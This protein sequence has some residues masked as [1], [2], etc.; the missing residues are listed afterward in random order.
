MIVRIIKDEIDIIK[1]TERNVNA[2]ITDKLSDLTM[3]VLDRHSKGIVIDLS[4]VEYI[5]SSGL[6]CFLS[7]LKASKNHYVTIKF[8][9]LL[10]EI[11]EL[12]YL[13]K[14][15]TIFPLYDNINDC[16]ESFKT[17]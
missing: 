1:I 10:P 14:L 11:K 9:N 15:E 12:F 16:L 2:L 6:G 4:A 7:L 3:Q 5:D 13:L 8:A 17:R